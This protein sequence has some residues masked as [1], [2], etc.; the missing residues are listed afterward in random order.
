MEG[1]Q[2]FSPSGDWD[3]DCRQYQFVAEGHVARYE[4]R[5]NES[6]PPLG[7]PGGQLS[8]IHANKLATLNDHKDF[9]S[10]QA[11]AARHGVLLEETD[12]ADGPEWAH[13]HQALRAEA[14]K[15][16]RMIHK[17]AFDAYV[18]PGRTAVSEPQG[19]G[20]RGRA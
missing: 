19:A 6:K 5:L 8:R 15:L 1:M 9:W 11:E 2:K 17:T 18:H 3:K 20:S 10:R 12:V 16:G 7:N 14:I 13:N 4:R